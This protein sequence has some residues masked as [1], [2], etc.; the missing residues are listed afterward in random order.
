M[1]AFI[2]EAIEEYIAASRR[3]RIEYV[4]VAGD[5]KRLDLEPFFHIT[6]IDAVIAVVGDPP[7]VIYLL[8]LSTS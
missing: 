6:N 2:R 8:A 1:V 3:F 7:A 5:S 4:G